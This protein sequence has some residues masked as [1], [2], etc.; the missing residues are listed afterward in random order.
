MSIIYTLGPTSATAITIYPEWGGYK[1]GEEMDRA[2]YRSRSGKLYMYK[3]H[4]YDKFS[5]PVNFITNSNAAIVNSWWESQTA[6]LYFIE[7]G[8]TTEVF[9][10][11]I[12]MDKRPFESYNKPYTDYL[13]ATILLEGY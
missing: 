2:K 11:Y 1:R 13:K 4:T 8:A 3:Y 7:D 6:L 9:S 5:I 12:T 10:V